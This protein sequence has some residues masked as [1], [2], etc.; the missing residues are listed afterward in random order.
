[1]VEATGALSDEKVSDGADCLQSLSVDF[2]SGGGGRYGSS[3]VSPLSALAAIC[4]NFNATETVE[5]NKSDDDGDVDVGNEDASDVESGEG[6][7]TEVKEDR[8]PSNSPDE[9]DDDH[10]DDDDDGDGDSDAIFKN[11]NPSAPRTDLPGTV[12]PLLSP[13]AMPFITPYTVP[14]DD[15]WKLWRPPAAGNS[16]TSV[17]PAVPMATTLRPAT[18][19]PYPLAWPRLPTLL[20]PFVATPAPSS[21]SVMP[22]PPHQSLRRY[23]RPTCD[24]PNCLESERNGTS[25]RRKS[26]HLCHR[27]GKVY[28]KTSHL[29]AHLRWHSGERPF[30]CPWVMCGKRF[31]RSD[32]LQ[33]HMRTHTGEKRFAC[34]V[35]TKRFMRSD[36]LSKHLKTHRDGAKEIDSAGANE[37]DGA[38]DTKDIINNAKANESDGAKENNGVDRKDR[39]P[40]HPKKELPIPTDFNRVKSP[41]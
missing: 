39:L 33:R 10:D 41:P 22:P 4:S 36:H 8:I 35:C 21:G 13:T 3:D 1:M 12:N 27:C 7:G 40:N 16:S 37:S 38:K 17:P 23:R 9:D 34:S 32:E 26:Q 15:V 31:T 18:I 6:E 29:K 19:R 20:P 14:A 24:C 28:G 25:S 2:V 5:T 11:G 30:A